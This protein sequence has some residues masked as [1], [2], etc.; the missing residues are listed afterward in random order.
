MTFIWSKKIKH[1]STDQIKTVLRFSVEPCPF[2]SLLIL[3]VINWFI[4]GHA[5][6]I[7]YFYGKFYRVYTYSSCF[8]ILLTFHVCHLTFF[9][10]IYRNVGQEPPAPPPNFRLVPV[11][12]E[13]EPEPQPAPASSEKPTLETMDKKVLHTVDDHAIQVRSLLMCFRRINEPCH[14]KTC[15]RGFRP[16]KTQT[17][18]LSCRD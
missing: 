15:L 13:K 4:F 18:L 7:Y 9:L 11:K 2:I 5:V 10:V 17:I 1:I 8:V 12:Q 16:V 3:S 6:V 14:E